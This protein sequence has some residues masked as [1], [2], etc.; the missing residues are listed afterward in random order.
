MS[1][2]FE[3]NEK[4]QQ[5]TINNKPI[6]DKNIFEKIE[7]YSNILKD[8]ILVYRL[9]RWLITI[10][11]TL[12]YIIRILQTEGFYCLTYCISL[13]FLN[14]FIGFI[15]PLENPEESSLNDG[16]SFLPQ[17]NNEEFKPFQ[18]KVKEYSLWSTI[19]FTLIISIFITFI[20]LFD[21]PVYW[22]LLVLYFLVLFFLVMKR[23]IK[24]MIKYHY[25]P[26]D[27]GKTKY[28]K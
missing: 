3:E 15:S 6:A 8:K 2:Y 9:E 22:P 13:Y 19:T 23:Q 14:A 4:S 16:D 26:W 18:R 20:K 28:G 27:A 10:I 24:H 21:L 1:N 5:S 12:L 7:F 25:L 17:K 11:F